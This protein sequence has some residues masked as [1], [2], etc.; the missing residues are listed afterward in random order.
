MGS[1][2]IK[3]SGFNSLMKICTHLFFHTAAHIGDFSISFSHTAIR[4][5]L[6]WQLVL[7]R[8][9]VAENKWLKYSSKRNNALMLVPVIL[10]NLNLK[11]IQKIHLDC[12][13]ATL[14]FIPICWELGKKM[15]KIDFYIL[16]I[17]WPKAKLKVTE[18][19]IKWQRSV[20]PIH[21]AAWKN[22]GWKVCAHCPMSTVQTCYARQ[23]DWQTQ[24][25]AQNHTLLIRII[26]NM[27]SA[28]CLSLVQSNTLYHLY[29]KSKN[30]P[31]HTHCFQVLS[32]LVG[33][34]SHNC[35]THTCPLWAS[36]AKTQIPL[37]TISYANLKNQQWDS[38]NVTMAMLWDNTKD[39]VFLF[40]III[41]VQSAQL[42]R[43]LNGNKCKNARLNVCIISY[44]RF[45]SCLK[46][47]WLVS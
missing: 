5:V 25:I 29:K 44:T 22:F 39:F 23:T 21:K 30:K 36:V 3:R 34:V 12:I 18:S 20:V 14:N 1:L 35:N 13:D 37:C 7:Y 15:N 24:L 9:K 46:L 4:G 43:N 2:E 17:S 6:V 27:W 45:I 40:H 19:D 32:A 26:Q 41:S 10:K 11:W 47:H 28:L 33:Q 42:V 8:N 31:L 16:M 38:H